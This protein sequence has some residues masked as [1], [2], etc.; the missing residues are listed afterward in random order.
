[1]RRIRKK[2]DYNI[3]PWVTFT[4]PELARA[5]L[6]EEEA[7]EQGIQ[8]KVLT[9]EYKDV[10]RA[11]CEN[12][13]SGMIKLII[14]KKGYIIG[15]HILGPNAGETFHEVYLAMKE[16]IKIGKL[17]TL[18]HVYPTLAEIVKKAAGKYYTESLYSNRTKKIL[19]FINRFF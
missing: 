9:H 1:M 19:K 18:I 15:A 12:E 10:D 17:A 4:D 13:T 8:F 7:K 16:K 3:V 14:N 6:T 5:G 11:I 2:I